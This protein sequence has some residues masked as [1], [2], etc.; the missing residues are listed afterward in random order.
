MNELKESVK[1]NMTIENLE[2]YE[3]ATQVVLDIINQIINSAEMDG[4]ILAHSNHLNSKEHDIEEFD[5]YD[6]LSH[7]N[8]RIT[9]QN[10]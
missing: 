8:C 5:L 3:Y 10:E 1:S 6:L 7:F 2:G 4:E 9:A